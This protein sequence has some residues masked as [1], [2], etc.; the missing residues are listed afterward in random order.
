MV[1]EAGVEVFYR[2]RLR[3]GK[4]VLRTGTRLTSIALENGSRFAGKVFADATYE[5]DLMAQAGVSFTWGREGSEQYG[6]S[7]AGVRERTPYHQF[8]VPIPARDAQGR[9]WPEVSAETRAAPARETGRSRP[10]TS[11]VCM[12]Q[13][14]E[15]RVPFARP[16][17]YDAR[18]FA[19]LAEM[20]SR[21]DA[22]KKGAAAAGEAAAPDTRDPK[23][24]LK[25]PGA[26][27]T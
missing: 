7:L 26:C 12:T 25:Q 20:L 9:P 17:R 24:R 6:E 13:V 1:K 23:V 22:I 16:A 21:A 4:G 2:H 14:A 15:N 27:A 3:E 18:R 5:G 8:E 11:A 10:T 19:L